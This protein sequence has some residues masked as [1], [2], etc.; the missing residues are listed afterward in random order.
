MVSRV[1]QGMEGLPWFVGFV[2]VYRVCQ[3]MQGL[4]RNAGFV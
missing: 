3:G 1:C 4:L 2:K